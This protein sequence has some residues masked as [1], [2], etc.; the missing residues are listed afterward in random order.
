[1]ANIPIEFSVAVKG[2]TTG[3]EFKGVFKAV[4]RLSHR[5]NLRRDQIRRD[6]LGM[7]P[8]DADAGALNVALVFSKIYVHVTETPSWW[9]DSKDG[10]ELLDDSP[11]AAVYENVMRLEREA[12]EAVQAKAKAVAESK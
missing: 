9:K 11:V 8:E 5:G 12:I 6:L 4:A 10:L 3:E 7:R 1:M 2:E